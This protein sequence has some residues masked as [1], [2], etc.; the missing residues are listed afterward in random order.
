MHLRCPH[1][2]NPIELAD[3]PTGGEITFVPCGSSFQL[4]NFSTVTWDDKATKR[5]D[6][7]EALATV[8]HGTTNATA[9]NSIA[10]S[11]PLIG[12]PIRV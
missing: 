12:N 7:F 6:K 5:I 8:G 1:C 11:S 4:A 10:A 2:Q 3:L 9:D